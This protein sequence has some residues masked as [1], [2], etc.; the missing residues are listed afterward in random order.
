MLPRPSI[1]WGV[2]ERKKEKEKSNRGASRYFLYIHLSA[3][4]MRKLPYAKPWFMIAGLVLAFS[5]RSRMLLLLCRHV[6]ESV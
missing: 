6:W 2:R 4:S 3:D 5:D 1:Y